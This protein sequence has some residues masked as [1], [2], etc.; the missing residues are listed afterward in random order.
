[1]DRG[2]YW[3][4][5]EEWKVVEPAC[6]GRLTL[7][8]IAA[9]LERPVERVEVQRLIGRVTFHDRLRPPCEK[10]PV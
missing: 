10:G 8:V 7:D 3:A 5:P 4:E 1:M 9:R 6:E 2:W